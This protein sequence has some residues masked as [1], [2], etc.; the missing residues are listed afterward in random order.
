MPYTAYKL[1][2]TPHIFD[3]AYERVV[4]HHVTQRFFRDHLHETEDDLISNGWQAI[5]TEMLTGHGVQCAKVIFVRDGI[6]LYR[7]NNGGHFHITI[8]LD[9]GHKPVESNHLIEKTE[10]GNYVGIEHRQIF[11]PLNLAPLGEFK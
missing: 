10:N 3:H 4:C 11:I 1:E 7:N 6:K 2:S 5:A 8:S 9:K